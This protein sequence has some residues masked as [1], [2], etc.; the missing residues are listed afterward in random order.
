M[1][2]RIAPIV[3]KVCYHNGEYIPQEVADYILDNS[4]DAFIGS[5]IL[6]L[7]TRSQSKLGKTIEKYGLT[8]DQKLQ[9]DS[10]EAGKSVSDILLQHSG[11]KIG[12]IQ[13][14]ARKRRLLV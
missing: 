6:N 12:L 14:S 7:R 8:M 13:Q 3:S 1:S 10:S 5:E 4:D 11:E 9:R 2:I